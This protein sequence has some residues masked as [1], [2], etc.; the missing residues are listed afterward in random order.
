MTDG[1][2]RRAWLGIAGGPRPLPPAVRQRLGAER[3]VE[4]LEVIDGS[5]ADHAGLRPE[6]LSSAPTASP[7][8]TS[9][10]CSGC[11]SA[12]ASAV[13]S[14]SA[15]FAQE[16]CARSSSS[17][18]SSRA[19]ERVVAYARHRVTSTSLLP[20]TRLGSDGQRLMQSLLWAADRP[21]FSCA[22]ASS[23]AGR[24]GSAAARGGSYDR[25]RAGHR[26]AE[27]GRPGRDRHA[28]G[29]R[30]CGQGDRAAA[31]VDLR[32]V[33]IVRDPRAGRVRRRRRGTRLLAYLA[34]RSPERR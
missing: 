28:V 4:V 19:R 33:R 24:P 15:S 9:P 23:S 1:R 34:S 2:V 20:P 18:S 31:D 22:G 7:S 10:N 14:R 5:P 17:R 30:V 29:V 16:R 32:G 26:R 13:D 27:E 12:T 8:R 25:G 3:G 11:S 6:D 21:T